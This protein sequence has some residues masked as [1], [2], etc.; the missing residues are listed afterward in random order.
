MRSAPATYAAPARPLATTV[1]LRQTAEA[2]TAIPVGP[3]SRARRVVPLDPIALP[4]VRGGVAPALLRVGEASGHGAGEPVGRR[5]AEVADVP[6]WPLH[7][8]GVD[9]EVLRR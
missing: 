4:L 1:G 6:T 7:G 3:R 2:P 9:R 8:V 5:I